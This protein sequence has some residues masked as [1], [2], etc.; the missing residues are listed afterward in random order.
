MRKS[1]KI[2]E[3][4]TDTDIH[5]CY[6]NEEYLKVA[7]KLKYKEPYPLG[8]GLTVSLSNGYIIAVKDNFKKTLF[9]KSTLVHEIS[10]CTNFIM[11]YHQIEDDEFRSLCMGFL[12]EKTM[13]WF[14][15]IIKE[16][17]K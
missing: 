12:Y 16:D 9:A 13:E 14:D 4:L 15:K 10:H 6:G 8:A 2:H 7:K 17:T 11:V 1:I 5:I 3:D